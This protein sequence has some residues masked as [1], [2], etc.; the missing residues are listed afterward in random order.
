MRRLAA[1][2]LV[3]RNGL[4]LLEVAD[5]NWPN[6]LV[7]SGMP[8]RYRLISDAPLEWGALI[9]WN[10]ESA[11]TLSAVSDALPRKFMRLPDAPLVSVNQ[12]KVFDHLS[13]AA[14]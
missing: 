5:R 8:S 1:Q 13:T 2:G 9:A 14:R 7:F 11:A 12:F 3:P 10:G 4:H 6:V